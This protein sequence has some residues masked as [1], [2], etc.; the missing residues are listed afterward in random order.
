MA[1]AAAYADRISLAVG[2]DPGRIDWALD[3]VRSAA[4]AAGRDLAELTIGAHLPVCVADTRREAIDQLRPDVVGWAHMASFDP[5]H[6]ATHD[7]ILRKVTSAVHAQYDYAHHGV[8]ESQT[9]PVRHLADD[10]FVDYYGIAG[11]PDHVA[12]RIGRLLEKGLEFVTIVGLGEQRVRIAREVA[13]T[14]R[15]RLIS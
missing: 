4:K 6:V 12:D 9:S 14:L 13:P 7:P 2:A 10:E 11:P 8:E 15:A 1:V 3:I 5:T